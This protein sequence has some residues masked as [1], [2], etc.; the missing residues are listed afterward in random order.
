MAKKHKK[1]QVSLMKKFSRPAVSLLTIMS[2]IGSVT[3]T[4]QV[5]AADKETKV[6]INEIESDDPNGGEDWIEI[7]NE[8][9][10]DVDISNWFVT[11]D[12]D[13]DRLTDGT[14]WRIPEGSMLEAGSII[15]LENGTNFDFGLGK[16]DTVSLYDGESNLIDTYS[17][18]GHAVGTYSRMADGNFIDAESTKGTPNKLKEPEVQPEEPGVK[19]EEV[20]SK[21]VI[22]EV[23]SS[24]D[25][26]VE[27][28]NIG[29]DD[30]DISGYEIRDNSND[31]RWKF[32]E[33]SKIGSGEL[34][35]VD[36]SYNGLIYDDQ[37]DSYVEGTFEAAI[38]IGSGDSIRIYDKD[39]NLLDTCS[40]TEHA[41][42]DGDPAKASIGRYPDGTGDFALTKETKGLL[43][44]WYKPEIAINEIE[45]N[46]D[47]TDWVEIINTGSK[48]IDI[49]GW[50]LYDNDPVGHINDI[51]PVADG[52]ILA[53]GE[54][55]VF[56][57]N[58]NFTF[59]L[60]KEDKVTI[61]A[62]GGAVVDEYEWTAHA[63]GVYARIPDGT[64]DFVDFQT[65]TKGKANKV[66]NPVVL[67]E[68]QSN[69]K[70]G[71]ADWVELANP[72]GQPLDISGIV[73]K[74]N[75][76]THEYV[77]PEGT[78]I[79]ANGFIVI[80]DLGFG[81]GKGDSVRLYENGEIIASTTWTDHTN[82][83]WGLYPDVNGNEYK[84]TK[85]ETP[86][87]ANKFD[88]IPDVIEWQGDKEVNIL[89]ETPTFLEDSSGLDFFNG[90]LYAIDNGTGKFWILDVAK[91]G[92]VSFANGFENGKRIIF[93]KDAG[94]TSAKGPD[95]EGITVDGNGMVYAA[96]ERDNSRKDINY[97][98]VLMV[99]PN[100]EGTDLVALKEWNLTDSLPQ[101]SANMGIE[102]IEWVSNSNVKG[103]LFDQNTG[104]AFDP[105]NYP[106]AVADGVFF[107]ALEDNGHVYAYVLN[108][109]G[110][111]VQIADIDS[112]LGGA[113]ALDYDTYENVLWVA[114]DNGYNNR[115][116]KITL[117]GKQEVS[118]VHVLPPADL[119]VTANN[120]GFALAD[121][122][123]TVNGKR[124]VYRF[125]DGVKEGSLSLSW[126][127]CDYVDHEHAFT[128]LECDS[129]N[130]WYVC[131]CG[132]KTDMEAHSFNEWT[133]T[134]APT[135]TEKGEKERICSVCQYKETE[136]IPAIVTPENPDDQDKPITPPGDEDTNPDD[137]NVDTD[138]EDVTPDDG[139]VDTDDEDVAPGDGDVDSDND[140]DVPKTG[141]N[142]N[143]LLWFASLIV[144]TLG[145]IGIIFNKKIRYFN[146]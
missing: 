51:T 56:N 122:S 138:D 89:D 9:T 78:E 103:K 47:D 82:P 25:D 12:K 109:D 90:K 58:K 23:N 35:V 26:W 124:P 123:F 119:D 130:H 104:S 135:A 61:H 6:F 141:D 120:E 131:E 63:E 126:L 2:I 43:N 106:N 62:K 146:K 140:Q 42:Y 105:A 15:V 95:T 96:A 99:D 37:N 75:D 34:L 117:T 91:D 121:A 68:I 21:L 48:P 79:P 17:Y 60:G 76:D 113:M 98:T 44:D 88:D 46:G 22:N 53:P 5:Y 94:N 102:A 72:T 139:D 13:L 54:F 8:G 41:S 111:S 132:E 87:A 144:S 69:D 70:N 20:N 100:E 107:V 64:G 66:I 125:L 49:S 85:E 112:K 133:Q 57:Q 39:G 30:L 73:I 36:A 118:I 32:P 16:N 55:Y 92:S 77:I 3:P 108:N 84:N 93:Q 59:G 38:G 33:G 128:K 28:M 81:L 11:D 71:G 40:W 80:D 14:A 101:V 110:S 45:S 129:S 65:S 114:A 7:I 4:M 86:G 50:Y 136:E 19:P 116:A 145:F 29:I 97:N 1:R 31:H 10:T 24:P 134:K 52:T 115:A 137:G 83:T 127:N 142:T 67:N 143:I 27:L 18:T 74:D